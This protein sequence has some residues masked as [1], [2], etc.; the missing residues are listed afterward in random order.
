[1][2]STSKLEEFY[3]YK[4]WREIQRNQLTISSNIV[5]TFGVASVGFII[6]YLLNNKKTSCTT[7][8]DLFYCSILLFL[9]SIF[10][11]LILNIVKLKDYRKTAKLIKKDAPLH[12]ISKKTC[13]LGNIA[14]WLFYSEIIFA[15]LGFIVSLIIFE[16]LIFG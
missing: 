9:L 1:M 12:E 16:N 6:N 11:Y 8:N 7:L 2:N 5:F 15:F 14:W 10:S 3:N 13:L 4:Y